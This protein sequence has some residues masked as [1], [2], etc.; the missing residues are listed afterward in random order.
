M[1]KE[2]KDEI[3]SFRTHPKYKRQSQKLPCTYE[4]IFLAGLI[5]LSKE[6]NLLEHEK[7]ELE[8]EKANLEERVSQINTRVTEI[9]NRIRVIAPKRLDKETLDVMI[10]DAAKEYAQDI[11]AS[12]GADSLSKLQVE[13]LKKTVIHCGRDWGYDGS[14]FLK[15][16]EEHLKELCNTKV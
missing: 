4:D 1:K 5:H 7:G 2:P 15:L 12:W 6:I 8:L 10:N 3:I 13:R 16:V 14:K 9:N 11:F